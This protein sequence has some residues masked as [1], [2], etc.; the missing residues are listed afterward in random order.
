M[1]YLLRIIILLL[2]TCQIHAQDQS[3][4]DSLTNILP[5]ERGTE[6]IEVLVELF[7]ENL[8]HDSEKAKEHLD[9][10]QSIAAEIN[11]PF[12][13]AYGHNVEGTY[14]STISDYDQSLQAFIKAK[15]YLFPFKMRNV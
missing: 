9:E 7:I 5:S 6:R 13:I 1:N 8:Y 3:I 10:I 12:F 4:I 2:F 11:E 15:K 14:F